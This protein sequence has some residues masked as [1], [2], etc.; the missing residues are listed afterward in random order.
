[1]FGKILDGEQRKCMALDIERGQS[2]QIEPLPW[3]TDTCIGEWHY[4]RSLYENHQYKT[5]KTVIQALA[6]IVSKNGNLLLNIPVSGDDTIDSDEVAV[7]Q[8]IANWMDVNKESIFATRPWK[9]YG[10][11][12]ASESPARVNGHSLNFNEG[13]GKPFTSEDVRFT[14]KG[15]T[16]YAIALGVPDKSLNLKSLGKGAKL[17][18]REIGNIA[19][20]GDS[21]KVVWEQKYGALVI[22]PPQTKPT[23]DYTVVYKITLAD[24]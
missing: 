8:G 15:N 22:D 10:E 9:V 17:L 5:A 7:V 20:L 1:M 23:T 14:S 13:K 11:G 12:P 4:R 6:D 18:E 16:L 24:P 21:G 3:Q 19:L 2:N